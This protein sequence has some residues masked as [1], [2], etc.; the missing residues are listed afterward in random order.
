KGLLKAAIRDDN[1]V[2]FIEHRGL[3][4]SRGEVCNGDQVT[5]LGKASVVRAGRDVTIVALAK[6]VQASIDAADELAGSGISAEVIDPRTLSPLDTKTIAASVRKTSR[7]VIVHEAVEQGGIGA[8]IAAKVQQETFYH[9]D[10]PILRVA[11]PNAPVPFSPSLE[12]EFAP[13]RDRVTEAVR[14]LLNNS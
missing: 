10:S 14:K 12:R 6:M 5:P 4:R 2:V 9:L 7:L 1:P 3:Y 13:G 11:A 8:E